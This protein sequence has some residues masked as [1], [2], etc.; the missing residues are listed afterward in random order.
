MEHGLRKAALAAAVF[1]V[2]TAGAASVEASP[3]TVPINIAA[4]GSLT[5]N[6]DVNP[7][8][9]DLIGFDF[10][11]SLPANLAITG[12]TAGPLLPSGSLAAFF[13]LPV[14]ATDID[15]FI[16]LAWGFVI[17]TP[18]N[19]FSVMLGSALAVN[20]SLT[21]GPSTLDPLAASIVGSAS[22][23]D[24]PDSPECNIEFAARFDTNSQRI[25]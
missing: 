21:F 15:R 11:F 23:I 5:L 12:L 4:G 1:L 14:N 2:L 16:V 10:G 24:H 25:L 7:G 22:D 9:L 8:G 18:A 17:N 19:L 13:S 6:V 20:G 3:I